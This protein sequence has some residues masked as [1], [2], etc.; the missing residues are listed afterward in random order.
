MRTIVWDNK[1]DI[2]L[3]GGLFGIS[4]T[5]GKDDNDKDLLHLHVK[6]SITE[7]YIGNIS[8]SETGKPAK[9]IPKKDN[10]T[11]IVKQWCKNCQSMGT[12]T[13]QGTEG[14]TNICEHEDNQASIPGSSVIVPLKSWCKNW[15]EKADGT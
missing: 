14:L 5:Q 15:K 8:K 3:A 1:V 9:F 13:I 10:F 11:S 12:G 6:Q 2:T 4:I 7:E